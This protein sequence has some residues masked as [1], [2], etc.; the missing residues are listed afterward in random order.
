MPGTARP[1]P[2]RVD[3]DRERA[4]RRNPAVAA[5]AADLAQRFRGYRFGL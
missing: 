3:A 5:Y 1:Y 4:T 2:R